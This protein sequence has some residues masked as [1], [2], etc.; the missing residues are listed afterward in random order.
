MLR[1]IDHKKMG[2]GDLGWLHSHFHFSFSNY[3]NPENV[4][5]GKLRVINDDLVQPKTGF[6]THPHRDMEI[7]TYVVNGELTHA[8]SMGNERTLSRGDVQFMTAG[9]GITHSEYNLGDEVLRFLQIWI[10]PEK[11]WLTPNYG[12]HHFDAA[13]RDNRWQHIVSYVDG[14][15]AIR[16]NQD[17]NIY[18]AELDGGNSLDFQVGQGRQAYLV[19][20]EGASQVNGIELDMRDAMEIVEEDIML[21]ATERSHFLIIEMKIP[22]PVR[23]VS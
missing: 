12:D 15:A 20:I 2:T 1:K 13:G 4:K 6:D 18:V 9:S 3:Y 10:F 11:N 22:E 8:D 7:V 16:I 5:F 23:K 21:E 17:A 14:D 19:Q